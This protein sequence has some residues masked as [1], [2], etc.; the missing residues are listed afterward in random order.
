M[1]ELAISS[2][3]RRPTYLEEKEHTFFSHKSPTILSIT[4]NSLKHA[5]DGRRRAGVLPPLQV[6]REPTFHRQPKGNTTL[7][8]PEEAGD[9]HWNKQYKKYTVDVDKRVVNHLRRVLNKR[10]DD[11]MNSLTESE[12]KETPDSSSSQNA[13]RKQPTKRPDIFNRYNDIEVI[14]PKKQTPKEDTNGKVENGRALPGIKSEH[15]HKNGHAAVT[16]NVTNTDSAA[17]ETDGKAGS[18]DVTNSNLSAEED[19]ILD[20]PPF[21]LEDDSSDYGDFRQCQVSPVPT[22]VLQRPMTREQTRISHEDK[23]S[24]IL[25]GNVNRY[26]SANSKTIRIYLSS[27]FSDSVTERSVLMEKVFPQLRNFCAAKGF[28]L[29]VYDLHW[30]LKDCTFDDHSLPETCL[31]T[32]HSCLS[33]QYE[34][35][36]VLFLGEKYGPSLLPAKISQDDFEKIIQKTRSHTENEVEKIRK[37][38]KEIDEVKEEREREESGVTSENTASDLNDKEPSS[39]DM[40]HQI[41]S[42]NDIN[43]F[44]SHAETIKREAAVVKMLQEKQDS[45]PSPALLMHW[46]KLD[47]NHVPPIYRLQIISSEY[48]DF[49]KGDFSRREAGR[50]SWKEVEA[51]IQ[52]VLMQ[53]VPE[54]FPDEKSRRKFSSSLL[55]LEIEYGIVNSDSACDHCV[56]IHRTLEHITSGIGQESNSDYI[57]VVNRRLENTKHSRITEYRDIIHTMVSVANVLPYEIEWVAGG[58]KTSGGRHQQ[59]YLDKMCKQLQDT[60]QNRLYQDLEAMKNQENKLKL[61]DEVSHHVSFC[62]QRARSFQGRQEQLQLIKSYLLSNC[63]SPL[64]VYG[65]GGSG[66]T[67]LLSKVARD[68][69]TW[70]KTVDARIV[71]RSI[72]KTTSSVNV[73]TLLRDIC[74]Q[75]CLILDADD[76]DMP[77]EYKGLMN[78]FNQLLSQAT[79][80]SHLVILI[81]SLDQLTDEHDG[82][83]MSWLPKKLPH[84]AHVIVSTSPDEKYEC[85]PQLKKMLRNDAFI[86]LPDLPVED[87]VEILNHWLMK[88]NRALQQYQFDLIIDKFTTCALPLFLKVAYDEAMSWTSYM[89]PDQCKLMDTVKKMAGFKF[90]KMELKYGEATI[91][92]ALGYI[93]ASRSGVT[94]NEMEDLLSLDDA[95][96]DEVMVRYTPPRRHFPQIIWVKIREELSYYLTESKTYNI[97][98]I[99]WSHGQ[100]NEAAID[101][102]LKNKDKAPSYHKAMAEYFMGEWAEKPKPFGGNTRGSLRYVSSQQ[103]HF[104]SNAEGEEIFYNVRKTNELPYH[105]LNSQQMENFKSH[106]LCNFEWVLAKLCGTSLRELVEEYQTALLTEPGDMDLRTLSDAIQLSGEAL[107]KDPRQLASQ[108]VGRL[109]GVL[110]KDVPTSPGDPRKYPFL[111][112]FMNQAK[113]PSVLSLIPSIGCLTQ[114]GGVLFDLLSGHTDPITAVTLTTD[115]LKALTCSKDNTMKLWDL[116]TGK[117]MRTIENVGT[118]VRMI[119]PAMNNA[120]IVTVEGSVIKV[121]NIRYNELVLVIDKYVDPPEIGIAGE[122]KY[123]CALFDGSNMLRTWNLSKSNYPMLSSVTIDNHKV[124]QERSVLIAP[125]SFDE[126]IL[127]AFRGANVGAVH[128]ARTGKHMHTLNCSEDSSSVT[129]LGITRDYYIMACRQ[130]FMKLHE[131]FQL[132]LF[133]QKKGRYIRS[134]RG[135]IHDRI[136]EMHLNYI[137]SHAIC[138]NANEQTST[139]DIA[140]W[141][142]ETEDHKHLARHSGVST[143]GACSDFRFCLTAGKNDRSL[144]IWN[145]SAKINQSQ[146]KLKKNLGV[147]QI[148]PMVDNPRYVVARQMNNGPVSI[149]NVAKAKCLDKAVRIERGLSDSSDVVLIR[150]TRVIILTDKGFSANTDSSRPVFKTLLTYDLQSKRFIRKLD[151][152]FIPP[153]P[154]HEYVL[155]DDDRLL[156]LS[157]S[158]N[159]FV[160]WN[161]N[162]RNPDDRI[163]PNFTEIEKKRGIGVRENSS[164]IKPG[165]GVTM[166]PWDRRSETLSAKKRRQ[167]KEMEAEKKRIDELKNE[168]DNN[169]DQYVISGNHRIIVASFFAHHMCVFDIV[170]KK[171][172][173][174]MVSDTSMLFLHVSAITHEGDYIVHANYDEE[175]KMSFVT[176]WDCTTGNVK[177]RLKNESDVMALGITDNASRVIIGRGKN[178]LHIWDPMYSRSLQK[179]KGYRG[180]EFST[181][182]K[183][184]VI[185]EGKRAVVYAG[186]VSIWDIEKASVIA[187]FTPDMRINCVNIALNGQL[188]TFGLQ[189]VSDVVTLKLTSKNTLTMLE[190]GGEDMFGEAPDESSEE[191]EDEEDYD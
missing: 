139:T 183:I 98:T 81:D 150:N 83:K 38:L 143:M 34:I 39:A 172:T 118:S 20:I 1:E 70:F 175:N 92:R 60:I 55:D 108:M 145:I 85:L 87:A 174:T 151:S 171:H 186:D 116:R 19:E 50:T 138:I 74:Q 161:M 37:R 66:K 73:R 100:F 78:F 112:T 82:R 4:G 120:L 9:A 97:N 96:M 35:N 79:E 67:A 119:R 114:P 115:G 113:V 22:P 18:N 42:A 7:S 44:R 164:L 46:Y 144:H 142:V 45:L 3:G 68:T 160:I 25:N 154:A 147:N 64:V 173:Q 89:D 59:V 54:V 140:I 117:V 57:D 158:R 170:D 48:S 184:F 137:G 71:L 167:Q 72:G 26:C 105:L 40:S 180:L 146:P 152:C 91:K 10:I 124:F 165:L 191:E 153:L 123:L 23:V 65:P 29:D 122:G 159:H 84:Y 15:G 17:D 43:K 106:T 62:Q 127:V 99:R 156:S 36:M 157:D 32:L 53:I 5:D 95:V 182:S 134:V 51:K 166:T 33:S 130:N 129:S 41:N 75:L 189:E 102:Y 110:A 107:T 56:V 11:H 101:R 12:D 6:K 103:M 168:K 47:E 162:T 109:H 131:I 132:E 77:T 188:I 125:N 63:R 104:E 141:N 94:D 149:W 163:R 111:H 8:N 128:H 121:W 185:N 177:K 52:S 16:V 133:D 28:E 176:L 14:K 80:Q 126:R 31:N 69:K 148:V 178:E 21:N 181:E 2:L 155:L 30:G 93:A 86:E 13:P 76:E 49:V 169:I 61:F 24:D 187:I 27:G 88:D 90:S 190:Q 58:I 179:I 136:T 135:C